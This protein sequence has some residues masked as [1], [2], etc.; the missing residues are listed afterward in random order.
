MVYI[1]SDISCNRVFPHEVVDEGCFYDCHVRRS[2]RRVTLRA[3]VQVGLA[4][5]SGIAL[6][7]HL[8]KGT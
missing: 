4:T 8:K 2:A 5:Y 6:M 1:L 7:L 3:R